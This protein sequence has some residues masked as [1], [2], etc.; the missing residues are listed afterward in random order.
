MIADRYP[1]APAR[2]RLLPRYK[3]FPVP[4]FVHMEMG[5]ADFRVIGRGKMRSAIKGELCWICGQRMGT[6]RAF[7]IGPMCAINRVSAE[8][9]SHLEC[10]VFAAEACPFL[11]KPKMRRNEKGLPEERQA[12]PGVMI[13]RSPGVALVWVTR[14]YKRFT[15]GQGGQ[16]FD[17][18]EPTEVRWFAEGRPA[19]RDEVL[20]SIASGLPL[21]ARPA[22]EE[23][24]EALAALERKTFAAMALLPEAA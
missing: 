14:K 16:L 12:P 2:I 5:V 13:D 20:A 7:V 8:P 11:T 24:P 18:G 17:V 22:A 10:A 1:N 3:G 6:F 23:G 21:L 15:D 4:W 19:T 9:P